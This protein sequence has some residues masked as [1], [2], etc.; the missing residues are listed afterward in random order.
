MRI[1][2]Q[3]VYEACRRNRIPIGAA[4]NIEVSLVCQPDDTRYLANPGLSTWLY[5]GWLGMMRRAAKPVFARRL[6]PR[7]VGIS[8]VA[9][10]TVC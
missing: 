4:P 6:Q 8:A 10:P 1:V 2:F 5:E 7:P 9:A 3:H